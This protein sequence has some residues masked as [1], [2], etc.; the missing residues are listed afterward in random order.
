MCNFAMDKTTAPPVTNMQGQVAKSSKRKKTKTAPSLGEEAAC[1]AGSV[2][3]K[4]RVDWIGRDVNVACAAKVSYGPN[5][6]TMAPNQET[7]AERKFKELSEELE[8]AAIKWHGLTDQERLVASCSDPEA[9]FEELQCQLTACNKV[10]YAQDL[11]TLGG[12]GAGYTC[13]GGKG[14]CDAFS[15]QEEPG[16]KCDA[17]ASKSAAASTTACG[18]NKCNFA[19]GE[20]ETGR[21]RASEG[22]AYAAIIGE[23]SIWLSLMHL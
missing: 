2:P 15:G 11:I 22:I 1:S 10:L 12:S 4:V 6:T 3:N 20:N 23:S 9:L 16:V 21:R 14:N 18:R 8:M 5:C 19:V 13:S 7:D 17:E